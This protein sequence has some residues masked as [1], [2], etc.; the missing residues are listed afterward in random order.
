MRI[1]MAAFGFVTWVYT[2]NIP[3]LL[4]TLV[5]NRDKM[6]L[7][8]TQAL[9]FRTHPNSSSN[10]TALC[11]GAE[12]GARTHLPTWHSPWRENLRNMADTLIEKNF[13]RKII[14]LH[15][16]NPDVYKKR[17]KGESSIFVSFF[18]LRIL[19]HFHARLARKRTSIR[20]R[21]L[22]QIRVCIPF[23]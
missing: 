14:R 18:V 7:V 22:A 10:L 21:D 8:R 19:F 4:D 13:I 9:H 2:N 15:R 3:S 20:I 16:K 6:M 17:I 11:A 12:S 1:R 23:R 5:R